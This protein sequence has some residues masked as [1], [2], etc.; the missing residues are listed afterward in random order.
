M[1][2]SK[3]RHFYFKSIK[4]LFRAP[5]IQVPRDLP[6]IRS[7]GLTGICLKDDHSVLKEM[8]QACRSMSVLRLTEMSLTSRNL[9]SVMDGQSTCYSLN[10][11]SL[12]GCEPIAE[13]VESLV[14]SLQSLGQLRELDLNNNVLRDSDCSK[15]I[16]SV[17]V[18]LEKLLLFH[19][20]FGDMSVL[21]LERAVSAGRLE[22]LDIHDHVQKLEDDCKESLVQ[23]IG[24][25]RIT[26]VVMP[27]TGGPLDEYWARVMQAMDVSRL[28]HF[29]LQGKKCGDL[30]AVALATMLESSS[31][32]QGSR[33]TF[34]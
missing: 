32:S 31:I 22:S 23:L 12:H 5:G 27:S 26:E 11:L 3:V 14:R 33:P 7:L 10:A 6:A 8:L 25:V 28:E 2:E 34:C 15:I 13:D 24:L 4:G 1:A 19:T 29:E 9:S 18:R 17:G 30:T 16:D 21:A 20:R